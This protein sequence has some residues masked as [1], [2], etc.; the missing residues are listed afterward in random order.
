M[1][2]SGLLLRAAFA[3]YL[4]GTAA[5]AVYL[6]TRRH[7]AAVLGLW[8]SA[9]AVAV[10]A[11]GYG[12]DCAA[13]R[14]MVVVTPRGMCSLLAFVTAALSL[15]I[16]ARHRLHMM[17][18]FVMPLVAVLGGVA[19][20]AP[21][22]VVPAVVLHGPLFPL[23]VW[24]TYLGLAGFTT[25]FGTSIAWLV[26]EHELKSRAPGSL[27]FSL[28]PLDTVE[29]LS[30]SLVNHALVLTAAGILTG[31]LYSKTTAG[32]WWPQEPKTV[33][34]VLCW[35]LYA[36]VPV[37]RRSL[38]WGGRRTAW[39]IIGGFALVVFTFAALSHLPGPLA[40]KEV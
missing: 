20:A 25:A 37:L 33:A 19:V 40:T 32:I 35:C 27:M 18:A 17:G 13:T 16:T 1:L 29:R 23:H 30:L 28:P 24:T 10:H 36:A 11:G 12:M 8:L 6:A 7:A 2:T 3:G 4:G 38:G 21:E 26:Q 34:T 14:A 31:F 22:P 9:A 5:F 15:A 39:C